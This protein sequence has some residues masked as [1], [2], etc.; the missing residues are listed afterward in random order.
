M[1]GALDKLELCLATLQAQKVSEQANVYVIDDAGPQPARDLAARY[2]FRCW[3]NK[4]N[5][6][7]AA[8]CNY[9]ASLGRSRFIIFMNS[10]IVPMEGWLEAMVT[11]FANPKVGVVGAKLLFPAGTKS[12]PANTIQHA[13]MVFD[14]LGM[15]YHRYMGWSSYHPRANIR[16]KV[17]AVTGALFGTRR[18][19]WRKL[20]GFD[21]VYTRGTFE[22]M[23]YCIQARLAGYITIYT[24]YAQAYHYARGSGQYFPE[25]QNAMIF[26]A[27]FGPYIVWDEWVML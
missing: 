6:G 4:E 22:D 24:P 10:D 12:G 23:A 19:L 3:T 1:Y 2:G 16:Q 20:E 27:Q 25:Q 26:R 5:L 7:F 15:P 17:Q 13:G 9:G 21:P 8:T 11:E 18:D 14:P